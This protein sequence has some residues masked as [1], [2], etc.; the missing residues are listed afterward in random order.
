MAN[1]QLFFSS[2][3]FLDFDGWGLM[4]AIEQNFNPSKSDIERRQ[5]Q[6]N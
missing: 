3:Y 4:G 1:G 2:N 6:G 5:Q